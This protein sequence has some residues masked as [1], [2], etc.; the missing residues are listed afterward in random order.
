MDNKK[1][2]DIDCLFLVN[3]TPVA[4][5]SDVKKSVI[6]P[7]KSGTKEEELDLIEW[8][9]ITGLQM[10]GQMP[11]GKACVAVRLTGPTGSFDD[12]MCFNSGAKIQ[13]RKT[14]L[15]YQGPHPWLM[16]LE[17]LGPGDVWIKT[18][19]V[20][21]AKQPLLP[22]DLALFVKNSPKLRFVTAI[23][24][25]EKTLEAIRQFC[26]YAMTVVVGLEGLFDLANRMV[27]EPVFIPL[28]EAKK[29]DGV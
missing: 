5:G 7:C 23:T 6:V 8:V 10:R 3:I 25:P 16:C 20:L 24:G 9:T 1:S 11:K 27:V 21:P 17:C 26:S 12:F 13:D 2:E 4:G 15:L 22:L 19:I 14:P 29:A 28:K 18:S